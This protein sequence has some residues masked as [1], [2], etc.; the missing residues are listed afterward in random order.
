MK[1][2]ARMQGENT[3]EQTER[4]QPTSDFGS[5]LAGSS[6]EVISWISC[7]LGRCAGIRFTAP[8]KLT[9]NFLRGL[10]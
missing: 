7:H 9:I 2:K 3:G 1:K 8:E 10:A 4:G 5:S 6:G